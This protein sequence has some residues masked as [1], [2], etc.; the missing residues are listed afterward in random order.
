ML[1]I[2]WGSYRLGT[3]CSVDL[4]KLRVSGFGCEGLASQTDLGFLRIT[5]ASVG[6]GRGLSLCMVH[7]S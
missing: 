2:L 5:I 6:I 4:G 3:L 1:S 7:D